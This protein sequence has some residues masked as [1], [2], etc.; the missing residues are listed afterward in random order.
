M[1]FDKNFQ[2]LTVL[3]QGLQNQ[4]KEMSEVKNQ[5]RQMAELMRQFREQGKFPSSTIVN[6][7]GGFETAKAI[8]LRSGKEI[9][10]NPKMSK[11]SKKEDEHLLPEEE[12]VD[13]ATTRE[14][15]SLP[16]PSKAPTPPNLGKEYLE[17]LN[18]DALE[19]T[20]F[21]GIGLKTNVI[22]P[23]HAEN[24]EMVAALESL[25]QHIDYVSKWVEAK[26]TRTNDSK[27]V[28]DFVK[29][30]ILARFGIPRVIISD[31]GSHFCN[32]TIEALLKKYNVTHKVSTPYDPQTSG[33]AEVSNREIKQILEKTVGPTRKDWSLHLNDALWAYRIAYRTPIGMSYFRLIYGKPCHLPV[34]LEHRAHWAI[35]TFNM[36]I[37]A[38]GLHRKLQ[39]NELE[40]IRNEAYE[41]AHI[42][43]EKTKVVHDKMIH[44]KIFFVGQK[45]LLFNSRLRLFPVQIQSLRTRHEFK[46]N[47]HRL[48][49]YYE[50]FEEHVMEDC[51]SPC[52][53][54]W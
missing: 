43:K 48:K 21:E 11:Q 46:V 24:V 25:Q 37:D 8:T 33:Q 27:V 35:K 53:W 7:K 4:V 26:A 31:G 2:A 18:R 10:T 34:E 15:Q 49:P 44:S 45:V 51:T 28:V 5:I 54:S 20:I 38:A 13:K 19:T 32:Q 1:D 16:Q 47:G 12:E 39:L 9:G 40:E 3:T 23:H 29:T 50:C 36:D 52:R 6:P 14:E 30:N 41:N 22:E 17:F 42:Y